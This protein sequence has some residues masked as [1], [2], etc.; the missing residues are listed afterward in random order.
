MNSVRQ[1]LRIALS[2]FPLAGC[3]GLPP[4]AVAEQPVLTIEQLMKENASRSF[5]VPPL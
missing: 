2:R 1:S 3:V 4:H 5:V